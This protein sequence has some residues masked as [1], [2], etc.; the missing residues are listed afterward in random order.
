MVLLC[1]IIET[2]KSCHHFAHEKKIHCGSYHSTSERRIHP[3]KHDELRDSC[4][5]LLSDGCYLQPLQVEMFAI[6]STATDDDASSDSKA[7]P[8]HWD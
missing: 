7:N 6:K 3:K 2:Q 8:G 5:N 1:T 4:A